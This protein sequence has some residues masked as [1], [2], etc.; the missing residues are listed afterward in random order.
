[1]PL[2]QTRKIIIGAIIG[3]SAFC[4]L[5]LWQGV[6]TVG[7]LLTQGGLALLFVCLFAPVEQWLASEG[8]RVLFP[9]CRRPTTI[10]TVLASWMGSAVNTL[11][12]V[13]TIG[14]ELAK[15]RIVIRH[16]QPTGPTVAI[17]FVDKT[18][19]ALAVALW[20][21]SGALMLAVTVGDIAVVSS[22]LAGVGLL[23]LGIA[24]FAL[25]QK[26]GV[27]GTSV[28]RFLERFGLDQEFRWRG[29]L[30]SMDDAFCELYKDRF[31]LTVAV[32][33][34]IVQRVFLVGEVVLVGF[35]VGLPIGFVDAIILKGIIG[36]LRGASFAVPGG[37][38]IQEGGYVAIGALLGHPADL[39]L[40]VSLATRIREILPS[41]PML[42]LWQMTEARKLLGIDRSDASKDAL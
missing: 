5:F 25:L 32:S 28:S 1:M 40:V 41:I 24:I 13:A 9:R 29:G 20:G 6:E 3:V 18:A 27:L 42:I 15:T 17:M 33:L 4:A 26:Q 21:V 19:Q 8:W 37:I 22:A 30:E 34:R 38:G 31:R 16:G 12:P 39:M 2:S 11:L 36:A 35:L 14:G 23:L 7:T 10:R